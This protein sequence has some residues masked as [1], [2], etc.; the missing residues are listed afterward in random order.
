[1]RRSSSESLKR[2]EDSTIPGER[3]TPPGLRCEIEHL[4]VEYAAGPEHQRRVG[5]VGVEKQGSERSFL[6]QEV[7][8]CGTGGNEEN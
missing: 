8:T 3:K 6:R 5:D 7:V 2:L 1:M 4:G